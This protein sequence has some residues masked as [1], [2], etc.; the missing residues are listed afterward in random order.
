[1]HAFKAVQHAVKVDGF[2]VVQE[3][4]KE[5]LECIKGVVSSL[6]LLKSLADGWISW[7]VTQPALKLAITF[8]S[9]LEMGWLA[10]KQVGSINI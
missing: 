8:D 3:R 4:A 1:M 2:N 5:A 7:P 10:L 9:K 6:G